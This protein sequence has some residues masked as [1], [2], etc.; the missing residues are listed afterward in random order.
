MPYV[1][2]K[3]SSQWSPDEWKQF[4]KETDELYQEYLE[5]IKDIERCNK[6]EIQPW[7]VRDYVDPYD[8][9]EIHGDNYEPEDE[10][11]PDDY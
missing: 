1:F 10:E 5:T 2:N 7:D 4:L 11:D 3:K 9:Y 8:E 6:G